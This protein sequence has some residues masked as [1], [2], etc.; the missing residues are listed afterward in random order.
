MRSRVNSLTSWV[1]LDKCFLYWL[2]LV[3]RL[4]CRQRQR[5]CMEKVDLPI[6]GDIVGQISFLMEYLINLYKSPPNITLQCMEM[7]NNGL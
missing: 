6:R 5:E 7:R 3:E 1:G 4:T 2:F